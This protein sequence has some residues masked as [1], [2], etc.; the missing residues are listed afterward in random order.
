MAPPLRSRD[1]KIDL[2]ESAAK[3]EQCLDQLRK[4]ARD[5]KTKYTKGKKQALLE[6]IITHGNRAIKS[7]KA[8]IAAIGRGRQTSDE[9]IQKSIDVTFDSIISRVKDAREALD[10]RLRLGLAR[11]KSKYANGSAIWF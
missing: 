4:H 8:W 7:L 11:E 6:D 10:H 1:K 2:I 3:C 9:S 5:K